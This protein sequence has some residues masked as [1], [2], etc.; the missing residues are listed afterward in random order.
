MQSD[1]NLITQ[2]ML[3]FVERREEEIQSL[4]DFKQYFKGT[5]SEI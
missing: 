2:L 4:N 1:C 5:E 3:E